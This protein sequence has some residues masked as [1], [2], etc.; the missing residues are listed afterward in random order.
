V[1]IDI[2]HQ[3]YYAA[4]TNLALRDSDQ[5]EILNNKAMDMVSKEHMN[6]FHKQL[7]IC[8]PSLSP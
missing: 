8:N 3:L 7:P 1:A 6:V 5:L 4:A 2:A